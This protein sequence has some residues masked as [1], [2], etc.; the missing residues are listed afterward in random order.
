VV[1]PGLGGLTAGY[2]LYRNVWPVPPTP[3]DVLPY[4]V[5]AW[6]VVGVLL[7]V[8]LVRPRGQR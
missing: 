7:A 5:A 4:V 1:L 8:G 6:L 3:F 2:V